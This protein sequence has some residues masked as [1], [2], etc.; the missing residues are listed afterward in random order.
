[1][2]CGSEDIKIIDYAIVQVRRCG[3]RQALTE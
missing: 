1:M 2:P 3:G